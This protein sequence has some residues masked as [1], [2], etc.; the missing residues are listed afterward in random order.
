MLN[1]NDKILIKVFAR[2]Y[3]IGFKTISHQRK[4]ERIFWVTREKIGTL[5]HM[6]S[7]ETIIV[8]DIYS[9]AALKRDIPA[10]TVEIEFSWL[11]GSVN[12]LT[13]WTQNVTLPYDALMDFTHRSTEKD[14]PKM[15]NIL[16]M[17]EKSQPKLVFRDQRRLRECL[18]NHMVRKKLSRALRDNFH[19]P[20][21]EQII[22]GYDSEPFSFMFREMRDG[23]A[24]ICGALIL[25]NFQNDLKKAYYS[26]HT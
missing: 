18:E 17:Q 5:E 25:H 21:V 23:R 24:G 14:G 9:F 1:L 20:C 15:W 26:V 12:H 3:C 2:E 16:S 4:S 13:G 6:K 8:N 10:G 11:S 19:S 22:F 7:A